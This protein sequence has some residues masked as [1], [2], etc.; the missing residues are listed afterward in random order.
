MLIQSPEAVAAVIEKISPDEMRTP[1]GHSLLVIYQDLEAAGEVPEYQRIM[2]AT[3]DLWMKNILAELVDEADRIQP[4]SAELQLNEL[5]AA[6]AARRERRDR[7]DQLAALQSG[8]LAEQ[9]E[10]EL[11][12]RLF[13]SKR[14]EAE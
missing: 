14:L 11:L 6:W 13:E 4:E 1:C 2:G 3:E 9:E 5:L 8:D 10:M 7:R 12:N